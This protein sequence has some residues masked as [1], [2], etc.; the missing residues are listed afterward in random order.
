ML[1]ERLRT[2]RTNLEKWLKHW[3][4]T[5]GKTKRDSTQERRRVYIEK[6]VNPFIGSIRLNKLL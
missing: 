5:A 2:R 3:S 4:E 6:H 1:P